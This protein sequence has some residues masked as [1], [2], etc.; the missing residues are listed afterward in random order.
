MAKP[1][2]PYI[3]RAIEQ[4]KLLSD[5]SRVI[6]KKLLYPAAD[7]RKIGIKQHDVTDCGA[8]CLASI[9]AFYGLKIPIARIRQ[10]AG[11]DKKGT[12]LFGLAEAAGKLEFS[13]KAVK[14]NLEDI[15]ELPLP[16]IAHVVVNKQ[17]Q[18]YIVVYAIDQKGIKV[19]DP[20]K[21]I[22]EV[23]S[24]EDFAAIS[25]GIFLLLAPMAGFVQKDETVSAIARFAYLLQP[26]KS[27]L[28]QTL[29]GALAFT[30][31][32]FGTSIYLRKILDNVLP[33][34]NQNL[35]NLMSVLMI[36]VL[37]IQLLINYTRSIL[38]MRTGQQIDAR[39]IL[40]YYKHLIRLPQSFFDSMRT[41]EIISRMNDA[42]KIRVFI[43]D[44]LVGF[45]VN[46]FILI[47]SFV[48]MFSA[49]WKLALIMLTVLPLYALIFVYSNK[50]NKRTQRK[51][52]EDGAELESQL[53]ESVNAIT[54]I[55]RFGLEDHANIKTES[56]FIK[57]LGT[58]Y[59]SSL[60][61]L[62]VGNASSLISGLFTIVLL[63]CGSTFVI[64]NTITAGELL[65]FYAIVGYFTG[66][67][68]GLI[69]MNKTA[70]D[71][72]IAADRLFEIMDLE[73]E[74]IENKM[75]L[76]AAMVEDIRFSN[77]Q[78]R[79]GTRTDVFENLSLTIEKGKVTAIIGES[80]SGKTTL[81]SLLQG[82]YPLQS[83]NIFIGNLDIKYI[84]PESLRTTIAAVPQSI[85]L[86]NSSIIENIT[87]GD[88][89]P[90][91]K[92]VLEICNELGIISFIEKLPQGFNTNIGE[93]GQSL[94]GGQRQRI[95]I[96]R[97][98]YRN[99]EVLILDEATSALDTHSEHYIKQVIESMRANGKTI[100]L[101]A[102]RLSSIAGADKIIALRDGQLAEEGK[103]DEL[104]LQKGYYYS[105]W[106]QQFPQ[107][108]E[109]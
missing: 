45:A 74:D 5:R 13:A 26:H 28:L 43:N 73:Q 25:S 31:L 86:F 32:G 66:P 10:F 30:V 95:V 29:A 67:V 15:A 34:G 37:I 46:V 102:H 51:L 41:G 78:F 60:N 65:S 47:F 6:W 70:Q 93:N 98:L 24:R 108:A 90:D 56:R 103:H 85:D 8:A 109:V 36:G 87:V 72:L 55:K 27:I 68:V 61:S 71:A 2:S 52:M 101:I 92:R 38:T 33:N 107:L 14:T 96:A 89:Q 21:G 20:A 88:Y 63:W 91:M 64:N 39:L 62:A 97:A 18:H 9:S 59:A 53:V 83:G 50:V 1:L 106:M 42:V 54:T 76:T 49:Y 104:M 69:G 100:I 80:G 82:I 105:L 17:L 84:S 23:I 75:P 58:V 94:S 22:V 19:M 40:G 12:N 48:F 79:Y 16:A 7:H 81:L 11:T 3:E 4:L 57:L 44:V 35:L 77:V 99:P